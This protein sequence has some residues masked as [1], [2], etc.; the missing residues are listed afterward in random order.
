V[1]DFVD[2]KNFMLKDN[3]KLICLDRFLWFGF[4]V[5]VIGF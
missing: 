4:Y 5:G 2:G 3:C 1:F